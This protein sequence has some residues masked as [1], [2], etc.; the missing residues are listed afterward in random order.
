MIFSPAILLALLD[1]APSFRQLD[2]Y[3]LVLLGLGG[4]CFFLLCRDHDWHPA[5]AAVAAIV[6]AFGASAAWRIQHIGQVHSIAMFAIS[7]WLLQRALDRSSAAYGVAA[8][9]A[10]GLMVVEPDQVALLACYVIAG[11]VVAHWLESGAPR[12]AIKR[13]LKPLG[14]AAG[15]GFVIVALPLLM[16]YLFAES[17]NR[18]TIEYA[19]AIRGSLHPA[20][21]ITL[22]IGDLYGALDPNVEY[23]G[24]SSAAWGPDLWLAQNMTEVYLGALPALAV[25]T[26]GLTRKLLWEREMRFYSIA[27]LLV[28]GYA[29]G[30]FTPI[31]PAAFEALPVVDAFRRPADA[32]FILGALMALQAGYV[33]HRCAAGTLPAATRVGRVIEAGIIVAVFAAGAALAFDMQ[34]LSLAWHPMLKAAGWISVSA[35]ALY[36]LTRIGRQQPILAAA[37]IATLLGADLSANNGPN[38]STALTPERYEFLHPNCKNQTVR[39]MKEK[40]RRTPGSPW[41]DRVEFVGLGYEWPNAALIHGF[42][43]V[44]GNNPLR[45]K[46]FSDASGAGDTIAGPD[47]RV[48]SP[49][50]PSYRSTLSNMLGLRYIATSIPVEQI[51]H[52]L[53]PG[54]LQLIARTKDAFIYENPRA[55]PRVM[56]VSDWKLAKFDDLIRTGQWPLVFDPMRTVLLE[57]VPPEFPHDS[58]SKPPGLNRPSLALTKY[59]N[60]DVEI[61]VE[62]QSDGFVLLND[63][64]HPWWTAKVDDEPVDILRAN[65]LFRAV[66]VPAGKHVVRFEFEPVSGAIAELMEKTG[67]EPIASADLVAHASV[68]RR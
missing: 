55:L 13:S 62:T 59:A 43:H 45:L 34:R 20:S 25:L 56:F 49:L 68:E 44:L 10:G 64:W 41:R 42:D 11:K 66:Q 54:D 46:L 2:A 65:V 57:H 36:L 61:S 8:G 14:S 5:G 12:Q 18:P 53:A 51:D 29:L 30:R 21:L 9:I 7:L 15:V 4:L 67:I 37:A 39:L 63:V 23:W 47:Q 38:E 52:K 16:T 28:A 24:P 33:C 22:V 60:T 19:E 32:T 26:I 1:A 31:F 3:V 35:G 50:F 17:S 48:F 27:C 58:A 40:L 6:F